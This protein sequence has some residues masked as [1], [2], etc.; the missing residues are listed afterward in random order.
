MNIDTDTFTASI[1]SDK[2]AISRE[3]GTKR[4]LRSFILRLND[5]TLF[6]SIALAGGSTPELLY[7][8]LATDY[9]EQIPWDKLVI[10]WGDERYVPHTHEKS[11]FRMVKEALLDHVSIP[12]SQ[13]IPIPTQPTNPNDA[14]ASYAISLKENLALTDGKFDL[15]LLGMGDDGH[16]ASLFPGSPA[17]EE[18][19]RTVVAAPAPVEPRQR[20]TLTYPVLN[21]ARNVFFLVAG[22]NKAPG[23][24]CAMG[25]PSEITECP[26][27][28]VD[29]REGNL[30]WYVD[31]AAARFL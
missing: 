27:G 12:Q 7:R 15:I 23:I 22:E 21:N 14:A 29:P 10:F 11:N 25:R 6:F 24:L 31:E 4:R 3:S 16:T 8:L 30:T 13:V 9:R 19:A 2:E 18:M 26:S 1:H 20:I 5:S 28:K 17:L